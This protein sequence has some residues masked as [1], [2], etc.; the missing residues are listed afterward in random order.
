MVHCFLA[1]PFIDVVRAGQF[2]ALQATLQASPGPDTLLLGNLVLADGAAPLDA[3]VV[4]PHSITVLVFAPRGGRLSI[5]ALGYGRWQ[6]DGVALS[7]PDD[8]DNPFEQFREQKAAL[9]GWLQPRFA[10]AQADLNGVSGL[11]LFEALVEFGPDVEAALSEAPAGFRIATSP[12]DLP[13]YLRDLA[14]PEINLTAAD[15]TEWAAEW[16]AFVAKPAA[17]ESAAMASEPASA[18]QAQD[19]AQMATSGSTFLGQKARA[20]WGWLGANDVPDDDL[21]YGY[22]AT[23]SARNEEK[24]QLEQLRQQMQAD[25]STQLQAL[26][27]REAERERSIAQLRTE[28]AQAPPVAAEAT[29]LVSRL[30][31][32]T[33]EKAALEAEMQAS[34]DELAARNQELDAKIQQL[35]QLIGQLSTAPAASAPA[36]AA[37][38]PIVAAA[39]PVAPVAPPVTAAAPVTES[40]PAAATAPVPVAASPPAAAPVLP[41]SKSAEIAPALGKSDSYTANSGAASAQA[42]P[43]A[44]AIANHLAGLRARA[45]AGAAALRP[46]LRQGWEWGQAQPRAVLAAGGVAVL[47]L[48]I[49]ALSHAGSTPPVPFQENGRWGYADASGQP[50]IPAQF[51]AASPFEKGQAVVAKDGAY[52][53]VDEKGKEIIPAAYD[54]LNPYAGGYARARVG[55]AYTFIDEDGQEFDHYYF[56]A[57][58]FA[59]GHAAVLD[60]R[61]WHYISGPTEPDTPPIAFKEAYTFAEGLA[62]VKLP[63]GYTFITVDYLADPGQGTKPFGRYEQATDFANGQARVKQAGRSFTINKDGE[64]IK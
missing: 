55:D 15:I 58:D 36:P 35:S 8:F 4:R 51:T 16:A 26:E 63:D 33:R 7:G 41:N 34:R 64:E 45:Q 2:A 6:L 42:S 23:L 43:L 60:H 14:T 13:S 28:L 46:R 24:Q 57:L 11:V 17:P 20:L 44:S 32:E 25:L 52:G 12:A 56:N 19:L 61:G 59:E 5:P 53:F 9:A 1:S 62:R 29:A 21:P 47:G 3:V 10:P 30:G 31:A 18:T 22:T 50:V 49:W 48:G 40:K 38:P 37:A 39:L 54:A 27:V